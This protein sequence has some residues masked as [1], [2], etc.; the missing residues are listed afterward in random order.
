M[1]I[2]L[3]ANTKKQSTNG[4]AIT[5]DAI[6]T[7]GATLLVVAVS[8]FAL[9]AG[10]PSDSKSNT[11]V[12]GGSQNNSGNSIKMWYVT[13]PTVGTGHTFTVG[14]GNSY[15][16]IFVVAFSGTD[17]SAARDQENSAAGSGTTIQPGSVTPTTNGQVLITGAAHDVGLSISYTIDSGFTI[18]DQAPT[19]AAQ[20]YG[21]GIAYLIQGSAASVNPTWTDSTSDGVHMAVIETFKAAA[22]GATV[23]YPQLERGRRGILRGVAMGAY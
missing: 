23:T 14:V 15:P 18:T 17:T 19:V 7:T 10:T 8:Q 6:D 21:G 11:W 1:S 22:G 9:A 13:N 12:A 16:S 3:V 2:A 20:A 5:T 4:A